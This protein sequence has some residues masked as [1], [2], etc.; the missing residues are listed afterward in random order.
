MSA[1]CSD[2]SRPDWYSVSAEA[3]GF[4]KTSTAL[5]ASISAPLTVPK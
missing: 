5:L 3:K 2:P 1:I 4:A